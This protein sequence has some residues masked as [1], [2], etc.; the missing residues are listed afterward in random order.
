[1]R[2]PAKT[3]RR[4][5]ISLGVLVAIAIAG[6]VWV[7]PRVIV[8]QIQASYNGKVSIG[9]WWIDGKSSGIRDLH[10]HESRLAE[11]PVWASTRRVATDL[12]IWS[13]LRGRTSPSRVTV[14]SPRIVFRLDSHG[15]PLTRP[16][17]RGV[18]SRKSSPASTLPR[19]IVTDA[20]LT[21]AQEGRPK[22]MVVS[23]IVARLDPK[24]DRIAI[25]AETKDAA[26]GPWT[27]SGSTEPSF[28]SGFITL[29]GN[30]ITD[31]PKKVE[32]VPFVPSEVGVHVQPLGPINGQVSL[33]WAGASGVQTTTFV[34][35]PNTTVRFPTLG[36]T[37]THTT[38]SVTV[39]G[40]VVDVH[41]VRGE[42]IGGT[43]DAKGTLNFAKSPP[44][45]DFNLALKGIDVTAAPRA[46]QLDEVGATGKLSGAAHLVVA[47][48]AAGPDLS[49]T[50]GDAV[51]EG[52][53]LDGIAVKSLRVAMTAEGNDLRY[54]P[55]STT[56]SEEELSRDLRMLALQATAQGVFTKK[57][58][59]HPDPARTGLVLP[60]T[61]STH[62][63]LEDVDLN[64]V[65]ARAEAVG[66]RLPFAVAGTLSLK[67]DATIPLG[68]L[69]DLK[70]YV[71][72]GD[73]SLKGAHIFG[74]DLGHLTAR[75]DLTNGVLDLKDFRGL[76]VDRPDGG[77]ANRPPTTPPVPE[78][79]PLPPGGFRAHMHAELAPPGRFSAHLR[80]EQL[81][82][83]ELAAPVLSDANQVGG[84]LTINAQAEANV[85]TLADPKTWALSGRLE[86]ERVRYQT[87]SLDAISTRFSIE[88][89]RLDLLELSA[90]LGGNPLRADLEL[91]LTAPF[92]FRG[93]LEVSG[94]EIADALA[95]IPGEPRPAPAG[96]RVTAK[97]RAKGTLAPWRLETQGEGRVD[98]FRAEGVELGNVP[99][100]W[101]TV[102]G[103][104]EVRGVDAQ[105]FGGR[106]QLSAEVP[107]T[108]DQPI[109]GSASFTDIDMAKFSSAMPPGGLMLSGQANGK[110]EFAV[111][112]GATSLDANVSLSANE[113]RIQGIPAD[114]VE[115]TVSIRKGMLIYDLLA[116][117]LGG[118]IRFKG[119]L[120]LSATPP[121]SE[122]NARFQAASFNL[123]DLWRA[124]D[125]RGPI[126]KLQG[127]AGIDANL[128]TGLRPLDLRAHGIVAARDLHWGSDFPLG[129]L[130]GE[131]VVT[132]RRWRIE[133]LS[134]ELFLGLVNGSFWGD[135]TNHGGERIGF[136]FRVER[137]SLSRVAGLQP[138]IARHLEGSGTL[139]VSGRMDDTLRAEGEISVPQARVYGLPVNE[140]RV[141]TEVSFDPRNGIGVLQIHR[142]SARVAGGQIR[143]DARF[144]FGGHSAYTS[145]AQISSL[146][147]ETVVRLFADVRRPATGKISGR[148][149]VAG[150]DPGDLRALRGRVDL[151]LDDA[152]L[153]DL[154][155]F[156]ELD[157]F[158][159][160]ARGGVFDDG[161]LHASI[162]DRQLIIDQFT[163]SGR[164][165]QIHASG[166]IRF[167][168]K[169]D[170]EVL[171]N[172]NEII[173]QSGQ[174]L[175]SLIPGL[176]RL[177]GKA[178]ESTRAFTSFLSNRL[179]K[180]RVAGTVSN[181]Q[182]NI[183][184]GIA[185]T[186]A[187]VG[188]FGS[189]F[190]LPAGLIR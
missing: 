96:G 143:N 5:S 115:A 15:Q 112:P 72:R 120:P 6:W 14:E 170:M 151:D 188:F 169:I 28:G 166:T 2:F 137:A 66:I 29:T 153:V 9:G 38:G 164:L 52:G 117:S 1:M 133:P 80:G 25:S 60:K 83:T 31:V 130:R 127:V 85:S 73:L 155:V 182:V 114:A 138:K 49:G 62:I 46:W 187:A 175:V 27:L 109:H 97:A 20:E 122:A 86:S 63:E 32:L 121:H 59:H 94:W 87:A 41:D 157:R 21:V 172:T 139:R 23:G 7:I 102:D 68:T 176:R 88:D 174:N 12:S 54:Q 144:H 55:Q 71:F 163:L 67:A 140:L 132:P 74:V 76:L 123:S 136:D 125:L 162:V 34:T 64:K 79:G 106:V 18:G 150:P 75:L 110:I 159:G 168:G 10:L 179:L 165:A 124:W 24:G 171:I 154:P 8:G 148:I 99:I 69:R 30:G 128:R 173:S 107:T 13:L 26:W 135:L 78:T 40:P 103:V 101:G 91:G 119:D 53:N 141:P 186:S 47:L 152:S 89:G 50:T 104:I 22:P 61:L 70:G 98:K 42:A 160:S 35:F 81:P 147:L 93:T 19:V 36:L 90:Q 105:P 77:V 118:K 56:S 183:D 111:P 113:L 11:S 181:P 180:I 177:E 185:V 167:D 145:D 146:D 16:E 57:S 51:I 33:R 131:V 44:S 178:G 149:S 134:G 39:E 190:S 82:L 4:L 116:K 129:N 189:V 84:F 3:L 108:G 100:R 43:V 156:R 184:T 65:L 126:A 95:L 48:S 142:L 17:F 45:I 37:T 92:D 58:D 161:D 158:L